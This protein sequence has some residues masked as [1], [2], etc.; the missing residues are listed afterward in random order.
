VTEIRPLHV[1]QTYGGGATGPVY[2][3]ALFHADGL[4][5]VDTG[6]IDRHREIEELWVE[7]D[8]AAYSHEPWEPR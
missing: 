4:M 5:L 2:A 6:M 3:Y 1:A 8:G 7:F